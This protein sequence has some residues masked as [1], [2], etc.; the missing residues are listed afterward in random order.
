[1]TSFWAFYVLIIKPHLSLYRFECKQPFWWKETS[2]CL[3]VWGTSQFFPQIE[4]YMNFV[5][6]GHS[7]TSPFIASL[8]HVN[9]VCFHVVY[10]R[11]NYLFLVFVMQHPWAMCYYNV[12]RHSQADLQKRPY[13]ASWSMQVKY[14]L[15]PFNWDTKQS[16]AFIKKINHWM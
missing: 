12:W 16:P 15:L 14:T 10:P 3:L 8:L 13:M 1:M 6:L 11:T 9:C 4:N 5:F 7:N 2:A